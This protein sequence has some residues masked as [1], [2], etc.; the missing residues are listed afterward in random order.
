MTVRSLRILVQIDWAGGDV[1]TSRVWDG[2]GPFVD[3]DANVW[4][5]AGAL[6]NLDEI[7]QAIN[8]EAAAI[9]LTLT[10]A[11]REESDI[12]WLHYTNEEIVGSAVTILIQEGD[13]TDQPVGTPEIRFAGTIDDIAFK[14]AVSGDRPVST[15][16]VPVVNKF[17]VRRIRSGAVL[18]DADQR[19]RSAVLNP[20]ADPDRFCERVPMLQDKTVTWP[21][22]M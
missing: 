1:E 19:A 8:G 13:E 10:G 15:I 6:G 20:G 2:A 21:R 12:V 7:E 9:N 3:A 11:A 5:G 17:T 16:E 18:S 4:I 14:D 22:W